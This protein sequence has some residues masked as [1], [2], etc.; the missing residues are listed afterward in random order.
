MLVYARDARLFFTWDGAGWERQ[1]GAGWMD[2]AETPDPFVTSSTTFVIAAT[3]SVTVRPGDRTHML[4]AEGPSVGNSNGRTELG[5]FRDSVSLQQWGQPGRTGS[6]ATYERP[7]PLSMVTFDNPGLGTFN[8]S[9]QVR[10]DP[11]VAGVTT[12]GASADAPI[13]L[14]VIEC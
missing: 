5:I 14:H 3:F 12:L 6:V 9:L 7:G 4:V 2:S 10:S 8:Y 1:I 13:R 11:A